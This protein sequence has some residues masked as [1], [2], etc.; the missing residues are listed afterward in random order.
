M[1]CRVSGLE[2]S[3]KIDGFLTIEWFIGSLFL[4]RHFQFMAMCPHVL[5]A[6]VGYSCV[7]G[8]CKI[9][10]NGASVASLSK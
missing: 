7:R 1:I 10:L 6:D 8:I 9:E 4:G 5:S 3:G 2:Y